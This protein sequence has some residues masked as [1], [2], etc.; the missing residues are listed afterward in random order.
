MDYQSEDVK[1]PTANR[2]TSRV[3]YK[4]TAFQ[5]YSFNQN[6]NSNNMSSQVYEISN[7][8]LIQLR[9][10]YGIWVK[11]E[12]NRLKLTREN[13]KTSRRERSQE[14]CRIHAEKVA[15]METLEI[16]KR[17]VDQLT[18]QETMCRIFIRSTSDQIARTNLKIKSLE[19]ELEAEEEKKLEEAQD[20]D[21]P[22]V[23]EKTTTISIADKDKGF[24]DVK[25][26]IILFHDINRVFNDSVK[27]DP[28]LAALLELEEEK[29][30]EFTYTSITIKKP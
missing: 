4:Q 17:R 29:P 18:Q 28:E 6:H 3:V 11:D 22:V 24:N 14:F 13:F 9:S 16:M 7:E 30:E 12:I 5:L 26:N 23:D 20:G 1:T 8:E 25:K 2:N 19:K 21:A 10:D 15:T 27:D